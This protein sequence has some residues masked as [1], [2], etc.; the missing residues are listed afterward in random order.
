VTTFVALGDSITVGIGDRGPTRAWRGWA[1]LLAGG[2]CEPRLHNLAASGAQSA[3]IE[4]DQLPRALELRP[5]VA[6][7]IMGINDTLRSSFDPR[8]IAWSA[9]HTVGAL[10]SAGAEVLTIRLPD[11]GFMLGLPSV[12]ARPLARRIHAVNMVMDDVADRFGTLVFDAASDP[13]TYDRR[14]WSVDRMHPSER[15]HRLIAGR[16]HDRLAETGLP[17]GPRPEAEPSSPPPTRRAQA[18]WMATKGTGWVIKRSTDM[19]PYLVFMGLRELW[20]TTPLDH[21]GPPGPQVDGDGD[22]DAEQ[23]ADTGVAGS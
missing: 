9:E 10:R 22:G 8:R 15:G 20:A 7:V 3:D 14:M 1:P 4:H 6:S 23:T 11:P 16:F 12:L 5:D 13:E 19:V 18:A 17:L 2:L 21:T